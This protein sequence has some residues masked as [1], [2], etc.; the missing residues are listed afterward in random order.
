LPG[1]APSIN[2]SSSDIGFNE[3]LIISP[4]FST[5]QHRQSGC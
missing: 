5:A 1:I 2:C 4:F 3:S